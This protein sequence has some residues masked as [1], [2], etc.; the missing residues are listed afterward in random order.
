[1]RGK[2]ITES[3]AC[4]II[5]TTLAGS[6][7]ALSKALKSELPDPKRSC[8]Y[9]KPPCLAGG[10]D[11]GR[12]VKCQ[13][14]QPR[15]LSPLSSACCQHL[16]LPD[17]FLWTRR[18]ASPSPSTLRSAL[19]FLGLGCRSCRYSFLRRWRLRFTA[20]FFWMK[21][22]KPTFPIWQVLVSGTSS[23]LVFCCKQ[24]LPTELS[25]GLPSFLLF[26]LAAFFGA[27]L[28][29]VFPAIAIDGPDANLAGAWRNSSGHFWRI[30]SIIVL[31]LSPVVLVFCDCYVVPR[32]RLPAFGFVHALWHR[33]CNIRCCRA[34]I[35]SLSL[36]DAKGRSSGA[37]IAT[38]DFVSSFLA[39]QNPLCTSGL[40]RLGFGRF[41]RPQAHRGVV[42]RQAL[43][44]ALPRSSDIS[45]RKSQRE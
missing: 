3:A 36:V 44:I 27:R 13:K 32:P 33:H 20:T 30:S 5:P 8:R 15:P 7:D 37:A 26:W 43:G 35:A 28:I 42:P 41:F 12:L 17:I 24:S 2:A 25:N 31:S 45:L 29:M 10:K 19:S 21:S 1:M 40:A 4:P 39:A 16:R 11:F 18:P 14:W 22:P 38:P 6:F 34:G 9:C 23:S